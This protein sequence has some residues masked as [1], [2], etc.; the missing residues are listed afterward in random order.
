MI[1]GLGNIPKEY[2]V[3][4]GYHLAFLVNNAEIIQEFH[5]EPSTN[6]IKTQIWFLL[7]VP[8]IKAFLWRS[9][10]DALPVTDLIRAR[11]V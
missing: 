6:G 3:K 8:K 5:M 1:F 10:S 4:S 11:G 2:S 7:T 9:T